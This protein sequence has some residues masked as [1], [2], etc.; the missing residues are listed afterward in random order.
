[1]RRSAKLALAGFVGV[2]L[3]LLL[4]R[5]LLPPDPIFRD[6]PLSQWLKLVSDPNAFQSGFS[7]L[8]NDRQAEV[9]PL[10]LHSLQSKDNFLRPPYN[11]VRASAPR[12]IASRMREW[13]EPALVHA[14]AANWLGAIGPAA[15]VAVPA[16]SHAAEHERSEKVREAAI[17]ALV[18][19]GIIS[20][21]GP[22]L[23]RALSDSSSRV[24]SAAAGGLEIAMPDNPEVIPALIHGL[25]DSDA[26][27]REVCAA[28]LGKYGPR[29][30][31]AARSL[32]KLARSYDE[33]ADYAAQA[34][35][36][37]GEPA[38]Q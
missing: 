29:A 21:A 5:I 36:R 20:A 38:D 16:L 31:P 28:T 14:G 4:W 11:W 22:V 13:V 19:I 12:F 27:V 33:A 30:L 3:A 10:L 26:V 37:I 8:I 9:V 32:Q 2:I 1:M 15:R 25:G 24:R 23:V 7:E 18:R 35:K 6:K 17:Y 34:L